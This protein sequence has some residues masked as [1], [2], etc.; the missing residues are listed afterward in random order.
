MNKSFSQIEKLIETLQECRE[1][2]I[3]L[4]FKAEYN[5]HIERTRELMVKLQ[6][7]QEN[8]F[9]REIKKYFES[10]ARTFGWSYLPHEH[11]KKAEDAFWDLIKQFGYYN[12]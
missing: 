11:G 5:Q 7:A 8:T 6:N 4:K 10:E 3:D 2:E 1:I 12:K 9:E